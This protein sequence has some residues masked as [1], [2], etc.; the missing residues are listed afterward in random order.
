VSGGSDESE[1]AEYILDVTDLQLSA[2]TVPALDLR[3]P[4]LYINRE[5]SWLQF[6]QRVLHEALDPR[7]PLLERLKFLAIFSSNLDEFYQV[8][9]AGL[10]RQA[11]AGIV[12]RT[13]DGMTPEAQLH[14]ISG[15][16]RELVRRHR[17]SLHDEL[18]PQL[19]RH[20][21]VLHPRVGELRRE[22]LER[23]DAYFHA[24]VFPVLTPLAVDPGHPFPYISNL[25]LSLAVVLRGGDGEERFA[26][27]KVPKILPRWVPLIAPN[28]FVPLEEVIGANLES[29]FPGVEILGWYTFRITRNTDLQIDDDDDEAEDLLSLIQ[30]E[31]RNRRFAEV[32]RIEVHA[33]MPPSLRQL[34]LAEFSEQQEPPARPLTADDL[35]EVPGLLDAA[36]LLS[37]TA[38]DL[39]ELKDPPF[40]PGTQPRLGASR[41]IFDVIRE[42]DL[43]LHHTYDS[44]AT[45]VERFIQ[46]AADDPDVLAIKLTLYR[47]GGDSSI[48]RVLAHAAERG[49]QVAVLIELQARFDEENNIIWAQRLEDVGVHVSYGVAGLKT[50]AKVALV[51]RR[52]GDTMRRYVHIGTGNYNPKTARIYSDFGILSANAELGAD[53][54]D[55][56]NVLTGFASPSGYRRLIVAPRGMRERF[57]G[58]IRRELD[59]HVAGR[60]ARIMAKMNALV[61]PELIV[62]LY[63]ASQAGVPIDLIVRGICCLRPGLTGISETIRVTSIVGRFLE[64]SRAYYFLN[65]GEEEVYIGSADWMPRNLDRRIEAVSPVNDPAHRQTLRE[66]LL[67][68]WQD[69]RQAWELESDGSYRQRHPAPGEPERA[70]HRLL[71]ERQ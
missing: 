2:P 37:L 12:E 16:V 15:I 32:V 21:L 48:A 7:T 56:F 58:M 64:H 54:T 71:G 59:H 65:G 66:V 31:V 53:L 1:S 6:N 38:L 25:S 22:E 47:T 44:F 40:H 60:P 42:G 4:S 28:E 19:A 57:L 36:D 11:Y 10:K 20:G 30:E 68:M 49:K 24:N 26:R 46:T 63:Q 41:N 13:A 67:L 14:A 55:L 50:H 29:L 51:V 33:S 9:V 23:L 70:T 27:V 61:D 5:L 39:P 43:L 34:L 3:D 35:Y 45:S 18:L 17:H 8:R 69:N 52:E 62:A